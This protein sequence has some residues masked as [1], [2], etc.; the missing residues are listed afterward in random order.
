[1]CSVICVLTDAPRQFAQPL[2]QLALVKQ[3]SEPQTKIPSLF[4]VWLRVGFV[5]R[6][7][8]QWLCGEINAKTKHTSSRIVAC[9]RM[10]LGPFVKSRSNSVRQMIR[11]I[12]SFL[13]ADADV[14]IDLEGLIK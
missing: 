9:Y 2:G 7:W 1:M 4:F 5:V 8:E 14:P 3:P 12:D 11:R 10:T 6:L 13:V